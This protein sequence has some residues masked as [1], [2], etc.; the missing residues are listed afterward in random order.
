[1]DIL[2]HTYFNSLV[3]VKQYNQ[4]F[5]LNKKDISFFFFFKVKKF[6]LY[7]KFKMH[8]ISTGLVSIE[9]NIVYPLNLDMVLLNILLPKD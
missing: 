7:S 3:T 9:D 5:S 2:F 4:L 6:S 1:M 8:K